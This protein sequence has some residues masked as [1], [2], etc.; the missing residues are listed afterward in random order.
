MRKSEETASTRSFQVVMLFVC[1]IALVALFFI[2]LLPRLNQEPEEETTAVGTA[3]ETKAPYTAVT[4]T[5]AAIEAPSTV[6]LFELGESRL[7]VTK[8]ERSF[9]VED[10]PKPEVQVYTNPEVGTVVVDGLIHTSE[11]SWGEGDVTHREKINIPGSISITG[12]TDTSID[13]LVVFQ[14]EVEHTAYGEPNEEGGR[15]FHKGGSERREQKIKVN[16]DQEE[17][18]Y[19]NDGVTI[20]FKYEFDRGPG[21]EFY[22]ETE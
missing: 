10:E 15:S 4:K 18:Y 17:H 11:W 12:V 8:T 22:K 1:F 2:F 7:I 14:D 20:T 5:K 21:Y 13:L 3:A 19:N 16:V 6:S 9:S